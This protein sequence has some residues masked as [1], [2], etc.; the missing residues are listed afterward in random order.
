MSP[1]LV[2]DFSGDWWLKAIDMA[3]CVAGKWTQ[4]RS[5][6]APVWSPQRIMLWPWTGPWSHS[7]AGGYP[8]C[9][10]VSE[11]FLEILGAGSFPWNTL[12]ITHTFT[13]HT[14]WMKEYLMYLLSLFLST[15]PIKRR[16][17][18][19]A[20][21]NRFQTAVQFLEMTNYII[22]GKDNR[23]ILPSDMQYFYPFYI[24]TNLIYCGFFESCHKEYLRPLF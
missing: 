3:F 1:F 16:C 18:A 12:E 14:L 19:F 6:R 4:S 21:V 10:L 7:F 11:R 23:S 13:L 24:D 9:H 15:Q 5:W 17:S 20:N 8:F 22:P 2:A